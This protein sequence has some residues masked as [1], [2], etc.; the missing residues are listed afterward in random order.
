[1]SRV[2]RREFLKYIGLGV[3]AGSL[4]GTTGSAATARSVGGKPNFVFIL[5][6]DMG[7]PDTGCYG[8]QFHETPNIDRLAS[9]GMRFTDAYAACPVCSPTRASIMSGQYPARLG[10]TDFIT[11]HWR[12]YEKLRVPVN[13]PQYLPL[14]TVTVVEA[15]GPAGYVSGFFGKWHLGGTD[16]YPDKQ[17]FDTTL[18]YQGRHFGFKTV[19]PIELGPDA[20]LA[21]VLTRQSERFIEE[22]SDRPFCLFLSHYAVHIP[23]QARQE[24]IDKYERKPKPETGVN[25]PIYAAMVEHVDS[26]VGSILN[27]LDELGLADR[28]VVT[29]FSDNGGLH[30][31]FDGEG[32]IV[33]TNAPLRSEK[34]TL[35]EGGIREPLIVR[36][37]GMVEPGSVCATPV[38]SVDFYP[39]L[40]EIA[41][42]A[43]PSNHVLDGKSLVPLLTGSGTF[44]RDAIY[45]HYPHYHH[46]TPAGAIR[47]GN[48]KLIEFFED[49]HLELYNLERD[50]GERNNLADKIPS[51]ARALRRKLAGWRKS[52]GAEM[53]EKNPDYDPARAHEWGRHPD[54]KPR[55]AAGVRRGP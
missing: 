32:P 33:S 4:F 50:I 19:P 28:T 5:I 52:V 42:T 24:L 38:S 30:Q 14:D 51:R 17:G 47:D 21:E 2:G 12:P 45:W 1:M 36:W 39:T 41:G 9:R 46:S 34:G 49:G 40:L 15:L 18:T 27:K 10:L 35:Y 37:P 7:W 13:S 29:F 43:P 53:P 54:R 8:H 23:L 3:A 20:Y 6:D 44:D 11:G 31:R 48:W 22:N 26:S 25:N 16:H 55:A